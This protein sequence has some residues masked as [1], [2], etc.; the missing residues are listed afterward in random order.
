MTKNA[1]ILMAV[2]LALP[3]IA[4]GQESTLFASVVATKLFVVGA[5][6]PQT[7]VH[8]QHPSADTLWQHMGPNN[9]RAFGVTTHPGTGGGI[10]Y[11]AAGNGLHKSTDGG[12]TWRITTGWQITEVLTVAPDP[13]TPD[14]VY[15]GTPYGVYR[16]TDGC[17]SW[18]AVSTGLSQLFTSAVVV[19]HAVPGTVYCA[20]EGGAYVSTNSGDNWT[21]LG[22]SVQGIRT[23]VQHPRKPDVLFAGTEQHGLYRSTNRGAWWEKQEAGVEHTTFYVIVFDPVRPDT[24]YAAGYTTGVYKSVDGGQSWRRMNEGLSVLNIRSLAV[25][26]RVP[27]RV[28]AGGY[29]GGIFRSDDGGQRWRRVGLPEAQVYSLHFLP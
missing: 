3:R 1:L 6:N 24:M 16:S 7:G 14:I 25:D 12:T 15:L 18:K 8:F 17:R 10:I 4:D 22:L 9:I 27:D 29:W 28:Y 11:I 23:I 2:F 26:P 20:T 5:A 21:R 19:D 13:R